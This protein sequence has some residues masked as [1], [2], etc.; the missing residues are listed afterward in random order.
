MKHM[1]AVIIDTDTEYP[2]VIIKHHKSVIFD[3]S[4]KEET[5]RM[6]TADIDTLLTG[7]IFAIRKGGEEGFLNKVATIE[8]A[9]D[10][11]RSSVSSI[12]LV[13]E[14]HEGLVDKKMIANIVR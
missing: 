2:K 1:V 12:E 13:Q 9:I 3:P 5:E 14:V 4:N 6:I 10:Y 7:L 8:R 11:M